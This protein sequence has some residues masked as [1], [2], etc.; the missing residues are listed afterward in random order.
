VSG[1]NVM[2]GYWNDP[3]ATAEVIRDGWFHS[4][5]VAVVDDEGYVTIVDRLK[6]MFISGG[7]NVYPAEVEDALYS[8][9]GV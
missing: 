4:G 6:D 8:H 3:A 1:P 9:D 2:L 7:E 5:D